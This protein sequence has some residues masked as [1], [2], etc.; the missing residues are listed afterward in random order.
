MAYDQQQQQ[1]QA[2]GFRTS[3]KVQGHS[4]PTLPETMRSVIVPETGASTVMSLI[5]TAPLPDVP[6]GS[7]L[8]TMP[9]ELR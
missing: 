9:C 6:K 1:Q 2:R 4:A 7:V 8:G 5:D 3:R